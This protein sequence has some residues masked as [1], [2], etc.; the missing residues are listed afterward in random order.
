MTI[1]FGNNKEFKKLEPYLRSS[2]F[3][4]KIKVLFKCTYSSHNLFLELVLLV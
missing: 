3:T 4:N 1:M 2:Y